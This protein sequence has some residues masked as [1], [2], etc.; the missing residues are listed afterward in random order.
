V[1]QQHPQAIWPGGVF[2][3]INEKKVESVYSEIF[4]FIFNF[5]YYIVLLVEIFRFVADKCFGNNQLQL[6]SL[7]TTTLK[8]IS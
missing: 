7:A 2:F 4:R 6:S 3:C 5:D 8:G 1:N